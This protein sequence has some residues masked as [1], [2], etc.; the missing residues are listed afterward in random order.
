MAAMGA[1]RLRR[2]LIAG[3]VLACLVLF[4]AFANQGYE[5]RLTYLLISDPGM[6]GPPSRYP[7]PGWSPLTMDVALW[8]FAA[9]AMASAILL[10][11]PPGPRGRGRLETVVQALTPILAIAGLL[12]IAASGVSAVGGVIVACNLFC[13]A[14]PAARGQP[15]WDAVRG[16]VQLAALAVP[17]AVLACSDVQPRSGMW[18]LGWDGWSQLALLVAAVVSL[19]AAV[20]RM[21]AGKGAGGP[22]TAG[23]GRWRRGLITGQ[24]LAWLGMSIAF[25]VEGLALRTFHLVISDEVPG[26]PA[27]PLQPRP[28]NVIFWNPLAMDLALWGFIIA[29][30]LGLALK[31]WRPPAGWR[32]R[33]EAAGQALVPI[34][35]VMGL[36]NI[37]A[38]GVFMSGMVIIAC[39]LALLVL[40]ARGALR[41]DAARGLAQLCALA[42]PMVGLSVSHPVGGGGWGHYEPWNGDKLAW[43]MLAMFVAAMISLAAVVARLRETAE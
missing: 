35:G 24:T 18:Q 16:L 20:A 5:V 33:R 42:L 7:G 2:G 19:A 28:S 23:P 32:G 30:M 43:T 34:L 11:W 31:L 15:R 3:Q 4:L 29:G 27:V 1:D 12:N 25:V 37:V 40:P 41:W 22:P 14:L 36:L 17:I 10:L 26:G 38:T 6:V 9:A 13:L 21:G 8:A 39:N